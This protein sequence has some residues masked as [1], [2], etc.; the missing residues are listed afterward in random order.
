MFN[1]EGS[2]IF[3]RNIILQLSHTYTYQ[4][5]LSL[6]LNQ[7]CRQTDTP[8]KKAHG[9]R[10]NPIL[11]K[12]NYAVNKGAHTMCFKHVCFRWAKHMDVLKHTVCA[13]SIKWTCFLNIQLI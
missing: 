11:E 13:R 8:L 4:F 1:L 3:M 2:H 9:N 5:K 10:T 6:E 7:I 12:K